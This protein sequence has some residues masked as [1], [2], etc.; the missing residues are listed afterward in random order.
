MVIQVRLIN[1]DEIKI[2]PE[3]MYDI[4]GSAMIRV[5]DVARI[6]NDIPTIDTQPKWIPC[7]PETIPKEAGEYLCTCTDARRLLVTLIKWQPKMKS[8]NLSGARA[9]WKVIAWRP[10]PS[11]YQPEEE[12][13]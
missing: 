2:K 11:P 13:E 4:C 7:T 12:T 3:Y 6:I 8:W 9:Y 10:L 5:E 1:A